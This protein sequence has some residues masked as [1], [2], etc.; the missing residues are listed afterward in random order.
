[1]SGSLWTEIANM[2]QKL[3]KH[4]QA[5]IESSV[6]IQEPDFEKYRKAYLTATKKY[7]EV[8]SYEEMLK[9]ISKSDIII[10]GDYHTCSQS[11]RSFL[12]L[13]K[14][15]IKKE[16]NF[17]VGLELL[18]KKYQLELS[19]YLNKKIGKRTFLK[20]IKLE[21]HWVFDLW[22]NFE[23]IFDF[24]KYHKIAMHAMDSSDFGSTVRER[25]EAVGELAADAYYRTGE[26][27]FILIGDLHLAP[28]HLP[29]C[30]NE[31]LKLRGKKARILVLYE[32]CDSIYWDLSKKNLIADVN[33]VRI[34]KNSFCR[35]HTPPVVCQQSYINWLEN[36]EGEID[37]SDAKH[38]F[39]DIIDRLCKFLRIKLGKEKDNI[40]VYT[41]G[42]LSFLA[43]LEED[44]R[45]EDE[46][47]DVIRRQIL[48]NESY[49]I[50]KAGIVY[51]GSLSLNHAS[52]EAAHY[53]KHLCSGEETPRYVVDAFYANVL[54]EML[55]FF[56][57]K[58]INHQRKCHHWNDVY[59]MDE[60]FKTIEVPKSRKLEAESVKIALKIKKMELKGKPIS[61]DMLEG[62]NDLF[63]A[64][65]HLLGYML[66]DRL[67]YALLK[68][69][70]DRKE[71][72]EMFYDKWPGEGTP[73]AVYHRLSK[74]LKKVRIPKRM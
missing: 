2:Q 73:F 10:V 56:G 46:E 30:I 59:E 23:P 18:N 8:S 55:G 9:E 57:S 3:Y 16:K 17:A 15:V 27:L 28:K 45:F 38:N 50:A 65:S 14:A 31:S 4:N 25:D 26:K 66:G 60:Y 40:E 63:F 29:K 20:R 74:R 58:M 71:V 36:E 62:N 64:L 41:C 35:L 7:E 68:N 33:V 43:R 39:L 37:Y 21:E 24:C 52:E 11:Q 61:E 6:L 48:S 13:L 69:V 19:K 53:L 5:Y 47:L 12:R 67:Y 42:D 32:N 34:N 22:N 70:I 72:T 51:L 44:P 49:F 54:H 1:M